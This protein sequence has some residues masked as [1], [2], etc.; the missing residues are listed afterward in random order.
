MTGVCSVVA[1]PLQHGDRSGEKEGGYVVLFTGRAAPV[2]TPGEGVS[3]ERPYNSLGSP[4]MKSAPAL[5]CYATRRTRVDGRGSRQV[6]VAARRDYGYR[7]RECVARAG[8]RTSAVG[9]AV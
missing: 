3:G 2:G 1:V 9:A 5:R 8:R 6:R 4:R 7:R